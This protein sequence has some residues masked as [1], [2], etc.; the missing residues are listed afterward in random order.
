M[1][2][3]WLEKRKLGIGGSDIGVIMGHSSFKSPYDLFLE[4]TQ[5]IIEIENFNMRRGS[6]L[7]PTIIKAYLQTTG[8]RSVSCDQAINQFIR[9]GVI[10][11]HDDPIMFSVTSNPI[12]KGSPDGLILTDRQPGLGVLEAKAPSSQV[13]RK[14]KREGLPDSWNDQ[15]QWYMHILGL[16][17]ASVAVFSAEYW[18][19]HIIPVKADPEYQAELVIA[20]VAFW[21]EHVVLNRSPNITLDEPETGLKGKVVKVNSVVWYEVGEEYLIAKELAAQAQARLNNIK[22][23]F[24]KFIGDAYCVEGNGFRVFKKPFRVFNYKV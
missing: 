6:S 4:K 16:K 9:T 5:N 13:Y 18:E 22:G 2:E 8:D 21:E 23:R 24:K 3:E 12:L 20:G 15:V 10:L 1:R 19:L 11:E 17:W 7:E 14:I